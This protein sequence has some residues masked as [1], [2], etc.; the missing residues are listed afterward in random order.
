MLNLTYNLINTDLY[1]SGSFICEKKNIFNRYFFCCLVLQ[2][3]PKYLVKHT[4]TAVHVLCTSVYHVAAVWSWPLSVQSRGHLQASVLLPVSPAGG[5]QATLHIGRPPRVP[6]V[7]GAGCRHTQKHKVTSKLKHK[8]CLIRAVCF[9]W[10]FSK[11]S[12]NWYVS[13]TYTD[14]AT[15]NIRSQSDTFFFI[16]SCRCWGEKNPWICTKLSIWA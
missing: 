6:L 9:H 4:H 13:D 1:L 2:L 8:I 10:T 3:K 7:G 14:P 15:W 11:A 16:F 5:A 12:N